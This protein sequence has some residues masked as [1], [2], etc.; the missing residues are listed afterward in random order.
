MDISKLRQLLMTAAEDADRGA[1]LTEGYIES[2][3]E[4]AVSDTLSILVRILDTLKK[5][6]GS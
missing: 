5:E 4:H 6:E 3:R 1:R 2:I